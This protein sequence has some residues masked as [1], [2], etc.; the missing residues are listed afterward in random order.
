MSVLKSSAQAHLGRVV[1]KA[2]ESNKR[3]SCARIDNGPSV[4][5]I[6]GPARCV[7]R[8]YGGKN[9]GLGGAADLGNIW[10]SGGMHFRRGVGW[11][12]REE[13]V[14]GRRVERKLACRECRVLKKKE[15]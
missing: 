14:R 1:A 5:E 10:D 2:K 15:P 13:P 9:R 4:R 11:R 8:K 12:A 3:K 7:L 6:G